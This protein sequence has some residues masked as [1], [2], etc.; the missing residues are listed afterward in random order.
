VRATVANPSADLTGEGASATLELPPG[1][2]LAAGSGP[3]TVPLGTLARRGT[4]GSSAEAQW[5]VIA[6]GPNGLGK[7]GAVAS[8]HRYGETF[9]QTADG[10]VR[11][12]ATAPRA[13][14]SL[15]RLR[16]LSAIRVRWGARDTG[17]GVRA[18]DVLVAVPRHKAR[19]LLRGTHRTVLVFHGRPR[20]AYRFLVRASDRAGNVSRF[21][22]T[23]YV[24]PSGPR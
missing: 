1:Y 20:H 23:R 5:I 13:S 9:A 2:R 24:S 12:D 3:A 17:A 14:I 22:R 4:L 16:E 8:T 18:Y 6:G 11:V 15:R 7:L 19:V 10:R 21:A